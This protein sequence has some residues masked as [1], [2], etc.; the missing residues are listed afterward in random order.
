VHPVGGAAVVEEALV[1]GAVLGVHLAATQP[2]RPPLPLVVRSLAH[3]AT[4]RGVA[5]RTGRVTACDRLG[6]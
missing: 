2:D 6:A 5:L 4:V 1:G 3:A